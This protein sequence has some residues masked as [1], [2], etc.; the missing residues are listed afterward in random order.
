M[1]FS[2]FWKVQWDL[3]FTEHEGFHALRQKGQSAAVFLPGS[4]QRMGP[5]GLMM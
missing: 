2:H 4:S 5:R 1:Y 3:K